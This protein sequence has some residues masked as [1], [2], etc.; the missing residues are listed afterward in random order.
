MAKKFICA[1]CGYI[2]KPKKYK[3]GRASVEIILWLFFV[4]TFTVSVK[5]SI[6]TLFFLFLAAIYSAWRLST[7][8]YV[9]PKC[10]STNIISIESSQG[11][12]LIKEKNSIQIEA[13]TLNNLDENE[14]EEIVVTNNGGFILNPKSTFP[15]T[16]YNI[17]NQIA[18]ELRHLLEKEH[19]NPYEKENALVSIIIRTNL[20][21]KEID[22]YVNK[23]KPQYLKKIEDL[24]NS[25]IDWE[26]MPEK[27]KE[28]LLISFRKKAIESLDIRP[29]CDL[30]TLFECKPEQKDIKIINTLISQ[31]GYNNIK[32]YLNYASRDLDKVYIIPANHYNRDKFEEL[33]KV[34]LARRGTD[35]P[36]PHIL[37]TLTLKQMNK[38]ITDLNQKPFRRKSKAIE[39]LMNLTD[40]KQRLGNLIAFRELFQL[41]PLPSQFSSITLDKISEAFEYFH[42]IASLIIQTY[43]SGNYA[44]YEKAQFQDDDGFHLSLIEGWELHNV[45][46]S[47]T[48][49]YCKR[50]ANKIYPKNQYPNVPLHIGCRCSVSPI[51]KKQQ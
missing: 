45:D 40:I 14:A 22:E 34:G 19:I 10:K 26:T 44:A 13:N 31:Y 29:Y 4:I 15:I 9:C 35:I 8:Y 48:C 49:P 28:D 39:F 21:C 42:E 43:E 3:K 5:I 30:V 38:L 47:M 36:L 27:D 41:K 16:I 37:G 11:I 24:K 46:D 17:N 7:K 2:G 51:Y 32:F 33:V 1:D 18:N 25:T 20:H 50:A 23:F 12:Q 6:T